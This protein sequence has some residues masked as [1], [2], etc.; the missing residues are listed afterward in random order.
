METKISKSDW[1]FLVLCLLLG[2]LGEEAFFRGKIGISYFVFIAG[3]YTVFFW[4]YRRYTFSH[5]RIGYLILCC[6]WLL[7]A[8]FFLNDNEVFY[9]INI[10][11]IPCL[12][13]FHLVLVTSPKQMKWNQLG[14]ILYLFSMLLDSVK[15][16][17]AFSGV[18]AKGLKQGVNEEKAVIWK[19]VLIG[20]VISLPVLFIVLNLLMSADVQFKRM[21]GGI[22]DWFNVIDVESIFRVVV[23]LFYTVGFFGFMQILAKKQI[24]VIKQTAN[25]QGSKLDSIIT[26]TVLI[27]INAV[28]LLFTMVQFKYFFSGTLQGDFTYAE[29]ARKGFFEL[30]FVTMIN[31][32]ITVVVLTVVNHG[33]NFVKRFMKILLTILVLAS[34]IMLISAFMRLGMYEEAY[35]FTLTRILAH[36]FMIFLV[37]IFMYTLV[38]VWVEKLSLFHF[39]FISSLIYFTAITVIDLDKIVVKENMDR[40]TE[41]RKIDIY[42]L[43]DLSY[44]GVMGLIDLYE[45][46]KSINGLEGILIKRKQQALTENNPW[47]SY[48]LKREQAF[49]KLK[50]LDLN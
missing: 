23:I 15:Y 47:Q 17:A 13:I 38:K 48:N 9:G 32:S 40:Y 3:F 4:R 34:F 2:I 16:N 7:S 25:N 49:A 41:S 22:P 27:V 45:K 14:M 31:L 37:V 30:L 26:I 35:G 42:Y 11:A 50:K 1:L 43:N 20:L 44:T 5:Q 28:Y 10:M 36:S 6:I 21:I 8:S 12:V 33:T 19:K 29:Y 24:K 39:Y 46:D 18:F